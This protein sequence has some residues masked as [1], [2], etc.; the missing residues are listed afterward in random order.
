[1]SGTLI[2]RDLHKSHG[3]AAILAGV[4]VT[5]APGDVLARD[6]NGDREQ[7]LA[8]LW[9]VWSRLLAP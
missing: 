3:A 8:T 7:A 2:A 4:S 1:M 6:P 9:T 5:V